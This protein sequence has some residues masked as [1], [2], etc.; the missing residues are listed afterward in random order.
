L[1][2]GSPFDP[3]RIL[4]VLG[5]HGVAFIVIGGVAVQAWG[6]QRTT[7]DLDLLVDPRPS[8]LRRLAQALEELE[9]EVYA[10]VEGHDRLPLPSD[11]RLLAKKTS[12]N[13]FTSAGG[14]DLWIDTIDLPG[15]RGPYSQVA[16]RAT[17]VELSSSTIAIVG[18]DDLIAM[19]RAAARPRDLD[20]IAALTRAELPDP[21]S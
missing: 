13:L 2:A 11:P 18:R 6:H 3:S 8:N 5:G 4:S 14:L 19:K 21:G 15:A 10:S 12:W 16:K 1:S 20:D 7:R 9:T 17:R